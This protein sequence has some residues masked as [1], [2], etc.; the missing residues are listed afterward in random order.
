[1]PRE[2]GNYNKEEF[3]EILS[4]IGSAMPN[5]VEVTITD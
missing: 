5:G 2:S 1:V 3:V 4:R